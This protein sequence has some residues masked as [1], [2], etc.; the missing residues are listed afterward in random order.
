MRPKKKILVYSPD[1]N[2][3]GQWKFCLE[4]HGYYAE[5]FSTH[6]PTR[7]ANGDAWDGILCAVQ[8]L[9]EIRAQ[10]SAMPQQ[11][12]YVNRIVIHYRQG[13]AAHLDLI[14]EAHWLHF[15]V[16]GHSHAEVLDALKVATARKRGPRKGTPSPAGRKK[17]QSAALP[18]NL[19]LAVA[20]D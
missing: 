5:A 11:G 13:T 16:V 10:L 9:D 17:P 6:I 7:A 15:L 19:Q 18:T 1:P 2:T 3:A 14:S 12:P 4:T 8:H 20:G